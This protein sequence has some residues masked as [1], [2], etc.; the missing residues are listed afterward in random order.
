MKIQ[1]FRLKDL[2]NDEHF[3]FGEDF[4]EMVVKTTPAALKIVPQFNQ[5]QTLF[6][7]EDV[8]L[9][10]ITKSALTE[11]IQDADKTRDAM[12]RVMT[13]IVKMSLMLSPVEV[14]AAKRLKIVF[15]T[16]GS[17]GA[18]AG[19]PLNEET[20]TVYNLLT[21]L[22]APG[23]A[24]D[25][26]TL[27]LGVWITKLEDANNSV[28]NLTQDRVSESAARTDL[29]LK[30]VRVQIDAQYNTLVDVINAYAL[31]TP[32]PVYDGFIHEWN[33]AIKNY[34]DAIKNRRGRSAAATSHKADANALADAQAA[35]ADAE[36]ALA[37][38]QAAVVAAAE[39][40]AADP[41]NTAL[42]AALDAAIAAATE[43]VNK[44][45]KIQ[46]EI[47]VFTKEA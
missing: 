10:K 21:D 42:K 20:S 1:T 16:Y 12:Y 35:L 13:D 47:E 27:G 39:A 9:K 43:L 6:A 23:Y 41:D 32:N 33:L 5:W 37:D 7:Q 28:R 14:A 31:T 44:V 46:A 36:T 18:V 17:Y 24:A 26:A 15:D 25:V 45:K 40:A 38:A 2:R 4:R 29:V 30:E 11:E 3:R 8:A 19:K 22:K 34:E